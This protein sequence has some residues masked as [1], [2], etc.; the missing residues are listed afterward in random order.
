MNNFALIIKLSLFSASLETVFLIGLLI[1]LIMFF[2]LLI[3]LV[4]FFLIFEK[5]IFIPFLNF[6]REVVA[7]FIR[8]SVCGLHNF[9]ILGHPS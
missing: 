7:Y 3:S 4:H 5:E 1:F 6:L 8:L 2:V 9:L